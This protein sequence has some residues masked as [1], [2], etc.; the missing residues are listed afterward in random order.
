MLLPD[1]TI[2]QTDCNALI[3]RDVTPKYSPRYIGGYGV[4]NVDADKIMKSEIGIDL[5]SNGYYIVTKYYNQ[6]MG[7]WVIN[8]KDIPL[9]VLTSSDCGDCSRPCGCE[10]CSDKQKAEADCRG[11][12]LT[13]PEG[14]MTLRYEVFSIDTVTGQYKSEGIKVKRIVNACHQKQKLISLA[15]KVTGGLNGQYDFYLTK[16][17]KFD[18][19]SKI[20]F[21]WSKL[22]LSEFAQDCDCDCIDSRIKRVRTDLLSIKLK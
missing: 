15:D 21:A 22:E 16:E 5:G 7:D 19:M 14:C 10:G 12:M 9:N 6:E 13:F 18:I 3:F 2:E 8:A 1:F 17:K 4:M 11:F 20:M